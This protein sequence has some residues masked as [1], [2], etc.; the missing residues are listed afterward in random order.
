M[1]YISF[2]VTHHSIR[3]KYECTRNQ[4]NT[5]LSKDNIISNLASR[6]VKARLRC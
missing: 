1:V 6:L 2:N 3:Q 5:I 4:T